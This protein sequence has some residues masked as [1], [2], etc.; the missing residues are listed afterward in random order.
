M[1]RSCRREWSQAWRPPA[2]SAPRTIPSHLARTCAP[3]RSIARPAK[4]KITRYIAVDD[5]GT[6]INPMTVEGQVQGGIAQGLG[7]ALFEEAR[8]RRKRPTAYRHLMDYAVPKAT[9]L[10]EYICDKTVTPT[11][12]NPMGVKGVG[13]AGTIGSVPALVNAVV[14]ALAP[15]GVRSVDMPLKPE[16][17]W[18]LLREQ[19][20]EA[21]S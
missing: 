2:F 8:L 14:D 16:K 11:T 15:F 19:K 9:Q 13:E 12:S 3:W 21:R 18:N 17:L 20:L 5:C 7:Q 4:I 6:I 10:P 1:A